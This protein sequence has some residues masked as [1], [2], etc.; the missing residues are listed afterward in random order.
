MATPI[1]E[2]VNE[3][4]QTVKELLQKGVPEGAIIKELGKKGI[5]AFYAQTIIDNVLSDIEDK[6]SFRNLLIMGICTI[7]AALLINYYSYIIAFNSSSHY[8]YL[9][10]GLIVAGVLMITR[11]FILFR[12]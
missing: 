6:K 1:T 10:W 2:K 7:A 9:F 4:H 5:D 3:L 12:K 11:A 8:Y